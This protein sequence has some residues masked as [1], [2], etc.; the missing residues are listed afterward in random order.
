MYLEVLFLFQKIIWSNKLDLVSDNHK[1]LLN[2]EVST[3][4]GGEISV[5]AA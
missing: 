5:Q 4:A 3:L 2:Q 1:I